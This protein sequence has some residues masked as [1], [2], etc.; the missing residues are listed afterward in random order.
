MGSLIQ[1]LRYTVRLLRRGP[2]FTL[3]AVLTLALG[4]GTST[5]LFTVVRSALLR[6]LPYDNPEQLVHL[7]ETRER[8]E[9][10]RSENSLPNYTDLDEWNESFS[11]M[12]GYNTPTVFLWNGHA[13]ERLQGGRVTA[14]FFPLLGAAPMLGRGFRPAEDRAGEPPVVILSYRFWARQY[15]GSPDA[16]GETLSIDGVGRTVVGVMPR[17]FNFAP[18]GEI[19]IWTPLGLEADS[20]RAVRRNFRWLRSVARLRPGTGVSQAQ[21][22]MSA[23]AARLA[24]LHPAEDEGLDIAV[25]PL[26]EEIVGEVRPVLLSLLGAAGVLLLIACANVASLLIA[27][28]EVRQ[29]EI[30][31]RAALGA[32]R[33]RI[34]RQLLT[35]SVVLSL[36]GAALGVLWAGW[37]VDLLIA[38]VPAAQL[39]YLPF[40]REATIDGGMLAFAVGLAMI[41][42]A[43]FGLA[44]ALQVS[45]P[46]LVESLKEGARSSAGPLRLRLR[47]LLMVGQVALALILLIGGG[48]MMKSL[49][50]LLQ[51]DPG[52]RTEGLLTMGMFVNGERFE[53]DS[54]TVALQQQLLARLESLPGVVG[55]GTVTTMPLTG[56]RNTA[57]FRIEGRPAPAPG[58]R[59]EVNVRQASPGYFKALGVPILA[60][61]GFDDIDRLGAPIAVIANAA[62][63]ARYFPDGGAVGRRIAPSFVP[64]GVW[65]EIVG[66][67]GD[68]EFGSLDD[69]A[70]PALYATTTQFPSDDLNLAVRTDGDPAS[71]SNAVAAALREV[72]PT[73][74][75][76][77]VRT[78]RQRIMGSQSTFIRRYP[79]FLLAAFSAAALFLSAVG[80]Y[81]LVAYS[82]GRRT[83]EFGV[84]LALGAR[85]ADILRLVLRQGM[86]LTLAGVGA[87]VVAAFGLTRLLSSILFGVAPTDV[88]IF[89]GSALLLLAVALVACYRPARRATRLNPVEA[90]RYE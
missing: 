23:L 24:D 81:G 29:R 22:E 87:G 58:E 9:F 63:A 85:P 41:C 28:S 47:R 14:S 6:P 78:M 31:I 82:I 75:I 19:D 38:G 27:R 56:N 84:R 72:E 64:E 33:W 21:A 68:L 37:A 8:N 61:R 60:G 43:L 74:A 18:A 20:P 4:I 52:F 34:V 2:G 17:G 44:P 1:D 62:L 89:T 46:D 40:L 49:A 12:S 67:V 16:L 26:E 50:K 15:G 45:R 51:V 70:R 30:S 86:G 39:E 3:V 57:G 54:E 77:D 25:V 32:G 7:W 69:H 71:L 65:F 59:P 66:V 5:A 42:G 13:Q 80:I 10:R 36:A 55:A 53:D 88:L 48:L 35:E 90:L 76:Y 83:R 11:G 73:I 79:A